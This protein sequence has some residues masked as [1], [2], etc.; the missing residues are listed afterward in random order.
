MNKQGQDL[1]V[2]AVTVLAIVFVLFVVFRRVRS[3][4][5]CEQRACEHGRA[6]WIRGVCLCAE[7]PK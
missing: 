7:E 1:Y 4:H 2:V 6:T 3:E 5:E